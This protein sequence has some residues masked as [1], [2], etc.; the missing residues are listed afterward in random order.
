MVAVILA[1]GKGQRIAELTDGLPKCFLSLGGKRIIDHQLESLERLKI[2]QIIIVIGYRADLFEK[3]YSRSEIILVKNPT[4][5]RTNVL[6]SLWFAKDYLRDGFYF[7]HADTYFDPTI[8]KDLK[9]KDRGIVLCVNRKITASE[10]MKVCVSRR[11]IIEIGKEMDCELAYG[12][13]TGLAKISS[14]AA[15]RVVACIKDR[16]EKRNDYDAFF[17]AVIQD[18]IDVGVKVRN[19]DIGSRVSIEIDYPEDYDI[20]KRLYKTSRKKKVK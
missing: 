1:A 17:E 13:F 2:K 3:E 15:S 10:D 14:A 19:F 20:A 5:D 6:T 12:E 4:Y 11:H 16:I 7:M 8:L 18:L 9:Q